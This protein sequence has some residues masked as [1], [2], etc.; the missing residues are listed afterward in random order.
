MVFFFEENFGV[1]SISFSDYMS[2]VDI[3]FDFTTTTARPSHHHRQRSRHTTDR[4]AAIIAIPVNMK[5]T[6]P[7]SASSPVSPERTDTESILNKHLSTEYHLTSVLPTL[8]TRLSTKYIN[9]EYGYANHA[10]IVTKLSPCE[11]FLMTSVH[12]F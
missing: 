6:T 2:L 3:N 1:P 5:Q 11:T 12:G 4:D 10:E 7:T 9:A 8:A